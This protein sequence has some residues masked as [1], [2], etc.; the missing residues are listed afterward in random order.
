MI[1]VHISGK[2]ISVRLSILFAFGLL[3]GRDTV[4]ADGGWVVDG[5][6][7]F[8]PMH[9]I[10]LNVVLRLCGK[11]FVGEGGVEEIWSLLLCPSIGQFNRN[12]IERNIFN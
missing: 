3:T 9:F 4:A 6:Q 7:H 12:L 1:S 2:R 11:L 10:F 8:Q 5:D